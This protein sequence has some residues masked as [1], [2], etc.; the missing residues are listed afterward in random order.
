MSGRSSAREVRRQ[1]I[2][3]SASH[4]FAENDYLAVS[5]EAVARRAAVSRGT[6]YN[7]FGSKERLYRK[8][9]A[10][11]FGQLVTRLEELLADNRDPVKDLERCVVQPFYFFVKYPNLLMLW[12]REGLKQIASN[13]NPDTR[14]VDRQRGEGLDLQVAGMQ[15]RLAGLVRGVIVTGVGEGAFRPVDPESTARAILGAVEGMACALAGSVTDDPAV[16]RAVEELH[17]FVRVSL[18]NS[19]SRRVG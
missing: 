14:G 2:L 5:M 10:Q 3:E 6:V 13:G 7:Y 16:A 4:V 11:R 15:E 9:L 18:L 17:G 19:S 1:R 8:V 12:R